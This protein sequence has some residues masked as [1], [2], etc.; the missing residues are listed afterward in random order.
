MIYLIAAESYRLINAEIAKIVKNKPFLIMNLN[1]V[2]LAEVWEETSYFSL[3][4]EAKIIV[5]SNANFWATA[6]LSDKDNDKLINYLTHPNENVT[7]IFTTLNGVDMRK[8]ISKM[9]KE[10]YQMINILPYTWKDKEK[11][12]YDYGKKN[13]YTFDA[14][15]VNYLLNN[16]NSLDILYN[17]MDKI[18]L[19]YNKPSKVLMPDVKKIVGSVVDNNNFHFVNAVVNKD[20]ALAL[21]LYNNLKV[22]KV[23]PLSLVILLA[24]EYRQMYYLKKYQAKH[25]AL[26]VICSKMQLQDWQVNK[27]YTNSLSY[28]DTELLNNLRLLGEMDVNIKTGLWDKDAA[29]MN[30]LVN[31]CG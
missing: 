27:L 11:A 21:K 20:L 29:L 12:I 23:E 5:V 28:T 25:L 18:F 6:K 30:F 9:I 14:E 2:S 17:E 19:Y 22:Y 3:T 13:G 16:T 7:L 26:P 8:K 31:I 24:R 1:K 4:N 10:K 15:V